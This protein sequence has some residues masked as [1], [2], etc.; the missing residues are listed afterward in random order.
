[1]FLTGRADDPPTACGVGITD[2]YTALHIAIGVLAALAHRAATGEGQKIEVDLFS[3]TVAM[4]QQELTYFLGHGELPPRAVENLG[5]VW[6]TAPFGIYE[7]SNGSI[8]IAMTP[9]PVLAEALDL[10][11]P[12]AVRH[13]RQDGR[14]AP[15]DLRAP[16]RAP[17]R[18]HERALDRDP[19]RARRVV[20]AGADLRAARRRPAGRAQQA[21]LGR[22]GRRRRGHVPH[23][24]LAD[25]VLAHARGHPHGVPRAG[26]HTNELFPDQA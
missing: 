7:T 23:A 24:G 11:V 10:L 16:R 22:P 20:R 9:C 12:R 17:P 2:Q 1:M 4:Q 15:R 19:A 6:A 5:S 14:V 25:H 26:Q 21:V 8:A 18:R 13:A 3:C